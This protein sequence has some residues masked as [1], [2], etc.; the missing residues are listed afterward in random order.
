LERLEILAP[1]R[2]GFYN[3]ATKQGRVSRFQLTSFG[4][5]LLIDENR[6]YLRKLNHD[7]KLR[8]RLENNRRAKKCRL[9]ANEDY[10]TLRTHQN[11][12]D[13]RKN[14]EIYDSILTKF[15]EQLKN[16]KTLSPDKKE[17]KK[18]NVKAAIISIETSRFEEIKRCNTDGRLYHPF[19]M[20]KSNFRPAFTLRGK[21]FLR[22][23]DIRSCYPSFWAKYIYDIIK[24]SEYLSLNPELEKALKDNNKE[25][26]SELTNNSI[27][28][29]SIYYNNMY[30]LFLWLVFW[31]WCSLFTFA[32]PNKVTRF[33]VSGL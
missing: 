27:Y 3:R 6:E 13:L 5:N 10:V 19:V 32:V 14:Q 23:I 29:N 33:F 22:N 1:P 26:I 15:N 8:K 11:I 30:L 16:D 28:P 18:N 4:L 9:P 20:M 17:R 2:R 21:K 12:L 24:L 31:N 7:P 25:L